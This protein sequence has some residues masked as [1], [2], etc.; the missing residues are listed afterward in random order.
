MSN[1]DNNNNKFWYGTHYSDNTVKCEWGRIGA[2]I[3]SVVKPFVAVIRLK[4]F[5]F[6]RVAK[7]RR[8]AIVC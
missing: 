4:H 7:K 3:S 5:L 6:R 1:I 2:K 8:R